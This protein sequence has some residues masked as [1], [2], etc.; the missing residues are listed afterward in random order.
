MEMKATDEYAK[1][2]DSRLRVALIIMLPS[3]VSIFFSYDLSIVWGLK[4]KKKK[5][6]RKKN[7]RRK[8]VQAG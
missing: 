4:K 5:N 2:D 7:G 6:E 8:P 3:H 1:A